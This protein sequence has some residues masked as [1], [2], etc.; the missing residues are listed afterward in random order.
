[1]TLSDEDRLAAAEHALRLDAGEARAAARRLVAADPDF[2]QEVADWEA[3]L[4]PLWD[5]VAE[6]APPAR[7]R[8]RLRARLFGTPGRDWGRGRGR[9]RGRWAGLAGWLAAGVS[10]AALAAVLLLP[11][12]QAPPPGPLAV[13]EIA[14]EGD[15]LRVLAAYDPAEGGFRLRRLAGAP[16]PGRDFE[17]W[18]IPAGGAPVSLGVLGEAGIAILPEA[19]RGELAGLTLAISD[20]AEGGSAT[21]APG[22]VLAAEAVTPL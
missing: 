3:A 16:A 7:V 19:L 17:L 21:G 8:R 15:G 13:A 11:A 10:A 22:T 14:T 4:A 5:D 12:A 9:G 18:A 6:I 1:M 2:R 20:E